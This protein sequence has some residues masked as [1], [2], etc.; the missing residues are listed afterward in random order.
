MH[1]KRPNS[2]GDRSHDSPIKESFSLKRNVKRLIA[3]SKVF[4]PTTFTSNPNTTS[5]YV[6]QLQETVQADAVKE[7][8]SQLQTTSL[9]IGNGR[10]VS[11]LHSKLDKVSQQNHTNLKV[12][13]MLLLQNSNQSNI[14]S[15]QQ[16][17]THIHGLNANDNILSSK[18]F[19][20]DT[21]ADISFIGTEPHPTGIVLQRSDYYT[22][23]SLDKL[24]DF[25]TNDGKCIV[26]NFTVGRK[27]Y[28]NVYFDEPIDVAGLN[29]D[30]IV[31]FHNKVVII[32]PDDDNKPP[33]GEGLNRKA[34]IT[35]Y[36]VW[37]HDKTLHEPIKNRER[38][39]YNKFLA[40]LRTIN[41]TQFK[42]YRPESGSWIF[43]VQHFSKYSYD[44]DNID[45]DRPQ[46]A[47]VMLIH[48]SVR[49]KM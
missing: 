22:I 44:D 1:P 23:P 43:M 41:D 21:N 26:P 24:T 27:G 19:L 12:S 7:L 2:Y 35:L 42:E 15:M 10:Q 34:R 48:A 5:V 36:Q 25:M 4:P 20:N 9:H 39:E 14:S 31:H 28:G 13:P 37:P 49:H 46:Y 45:D 3:K 6:V 32:Y 47:F 38:F 16:K 40:K 18:S 11:W 33:I 8:S 17:Y 30:E 29:L